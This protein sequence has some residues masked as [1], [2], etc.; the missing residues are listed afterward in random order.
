MCLCLWLSV[1]FTSK[2]VA[3]IMQRGTCLSR[4]ESL[5]IANE[6]VEGRGSFGNHLSSDAFRSVLGDMF[7]RLACGLRGECCMFRSFS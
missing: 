5:G 6:I 1:R 2:P 7:L 4:R 3:V